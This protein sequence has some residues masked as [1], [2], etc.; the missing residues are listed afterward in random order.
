MARKAL[1]DYFFL[2]WSEFRIPREHGQELID[3]RTWSRWMESLHGYF[4]VPAVAAYWQQMKSDVDADPTFTNE[5]EDQL[6]RHNQESQTG[7]SVPKT[8]MTETTT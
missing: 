4:Q 2:Y 3:D 8:Q 7:A 1:G 6:A 5:I